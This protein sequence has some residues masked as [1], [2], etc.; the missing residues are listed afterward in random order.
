M[1]TM[2]DINLKN[3]AKAIAKHLPGSWRLDTTNTRPCEVLL[4]ENGK[5]ICVGTQ[6]NQKGKLRV[7]GLYPKSELAGS[8]GA[9]ERA[10]L[11]YK[12]SAPEIGITATREPE[13]IAREIVRRFLPEYEALFAKCVERVK[14]LE[15]EHRRRVALQE[16]VIAAIGE[17]RRGRQDK[18]T[19]GLHLWF[20]DG[21][22]VSG[23][24]EVSSPDWV[25]IKMSLDPERAV[26][27]LRFLGGLEAPPRD[28]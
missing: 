14:D 23:D 17:P 5:G 12:E 16:R 21:W 4:G 24:V 1:S 18:P 11:S 2:R 25:S 7:Y 10:V 3:A 27:I 20:P 26:A 15:A 8:Y 9:V 22:N 13:A 19:E 28:V 6:W